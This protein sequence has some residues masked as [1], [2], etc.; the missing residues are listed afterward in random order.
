[1]T[2]LGDR[3]DEFFDF[4]NEIF[5]ESNLESDSEVY[6]ENELSKVNQPPSILN[7]DSEVH[8][9]YLLVNTLLNLLVKKGIIRQDEIQVTLAE[10]H[11]EYI[12][13]KK[14]RSV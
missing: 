11:K 9:S 5:G 7:N 1:M 10:L 2:T 4:S 6:T 13:K 8:T 12:K 3:D 14:G